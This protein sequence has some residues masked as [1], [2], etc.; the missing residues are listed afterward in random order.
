MAFK[1]RGG[2]LPVGDDHSDNAE[3]LGIRKIQRADMNVF[4]CE[5]ACGGG[6]V[7]WLGF[8]KQGNLLN[9]HSARLSTTRLALPSL[10]WMEFASTSATRTRIPNTRSRA[11]CSL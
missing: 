6:N 2:P 10:R 5:K 1:K 9:L 8:D 4:L 7:S 3:L 11:V